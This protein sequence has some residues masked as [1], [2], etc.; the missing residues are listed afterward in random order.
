[1]SNP[2]SRAASVVDVIA[3]SGGGLTLNV[4]AQL[5]RLPQ[6]TTHRQLQ[7][8]ISVGYVQIDLATKTYDL[9][10]RLRR[11]LQMSLGT[12]SLKDIARPILMDLAEDLLMTPYLV[13]YGAGAITLL[14]FVLPQ[15]GSR[16]LVHPGFEFPFHASA[17]GKAIYAFLR[18]SEVEAAI[19]GGL[20]R[21]LA[22]TIVDPERLRRELAKVRL[23]GY[24]TNNQ[25]L[26]PGVLAFAAPI[27]LG[28]LGVGAALGVVGLKDRLTEKG[29]REKAAAALKAGT[30]EIERLL[31]VKKR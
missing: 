16:T 26:D 18:E 13:R 30:A 25:E 6:S 28:K 23:R 17:V 19:V 12:A 7:S 5:L 11:L 20:P 1:M 15:K 24:A 3:S 9:G 10:D 27:R 14:D 4:I 22:N 2:L 8:L 29:F 31:L 21:Y